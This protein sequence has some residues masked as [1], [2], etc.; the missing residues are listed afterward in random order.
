MVEKLKIKRKIMKLL[1][2]KSNFKIENPKIRIGKSEIN[3]KA[4]KFLL[5]NFDLI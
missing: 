3:W 4:F 1:I 2:E 5:L